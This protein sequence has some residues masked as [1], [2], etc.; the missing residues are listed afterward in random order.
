MVRWPRCPGPGRGHSSIPGP[1]RGVRRP[2]RSRR[3]YSTSPQPAGCPP[4]HLR[5]LRTAVPGHL[6]G[7]Q[8]GR[9]RLVRLPAAG[10][11]HCLHRW[12]HRTRKPPCRRGNEMGGRGRDDSLRNKH[13]RAVATCGRPGAG[14]APFSG[15]PL[16][17]VDSDRGDWPLSGLVRAYGRRRPAGGPVHRVLGHHHHRIPVGPHGG[18]VSRSPSAPP[19]SGGHRADDG[20]SGRRVPDPPTADTLEQRD[21][22]DGAPTTP[23]GRRPGAPRRTG[24]RGEYGPPGH[25][26]PVR[27]RGR[28][29][30]HGTSRG[31]PRPRH[32]GCSVSKCSC[33]VHRRSGPG[34]GRI[35][36]RPL[37]M[38]PADPPGSAPGDGQRTPLPLPSGCDRRHPAHRTR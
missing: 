21:T 18:V 37:G 2:V 16:L 36:P 8:P 7:L 15:T 32:S 35:N 6:A 22:R 38:A 23:A 10:H 11:G 12:L 28:P 31:H 3:P 25:C 5:P 14:T 4:E 26:R 30:H 24:R 29:F 27:L 1:R 17:P 9:F 34:P 33:G 19:A 20:L 13:C